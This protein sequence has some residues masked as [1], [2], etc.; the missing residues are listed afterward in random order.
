MNKPK[1]KAEDKQIFKTMKRFKKD[2]AWLKLNH[3]DKFKRLL[4]HGLIHM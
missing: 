3:P 4:I 2:V 1:L